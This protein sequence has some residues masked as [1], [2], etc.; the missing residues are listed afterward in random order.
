MQPADLCMKLPE[1]RAITASA[2]ML[3]KCRLT[4]NIY[5]RS[6]HLPLCLLHSYAYTVSWTRVRESFLC[7]MDSFKCP[8]RQSKGKSH[9][10]SQIIGWTVRKRFSLMCN[11]IQEA[12]GKGGSETFNSQIT[13]QVLIAKLHS[14]IMHRF[15][16][17]SQILTVCSALL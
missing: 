6:A 13:V 1:L 16:L 2:V 8:E 9:S 11:I 10:Y 3:S 12:C 17:M 4:C 15:N 7:R 14:K 5:F